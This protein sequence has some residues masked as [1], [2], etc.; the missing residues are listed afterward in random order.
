MPRLEQ[1]TAENL[2]D[3]VQEFLGELKAEE[4][5]DALEKA[6]PS[7]RRLPE[8]YYLRGVAYLIVGDFDLAVEDL[9]LVVRNRE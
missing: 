6:S 2:F 8:F 9:E 7:V 4:A 5:L 1:Q 3:R